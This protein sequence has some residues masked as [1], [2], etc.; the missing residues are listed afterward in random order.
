MSTST[1][2]RMLALVTLLI[3]SIPAHAQETKRRPMQ[4]DDLFRFKRVVEPRISPDGKTVV[5]AV[6]DVDLEQNKTV[7]HLWIASSDEK[8]GSPQQLT[9]AIKSDRS[10]RWSP[11]GKHILF[12]ST[13]SG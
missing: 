12:E 8:T 6:G 9:N 10:P 13:R 7:Y 1:F 11:D 4:I 2:S 3:A 5:Y